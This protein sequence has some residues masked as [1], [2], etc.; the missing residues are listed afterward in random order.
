MSKPGVL[1]KEDAQLGT[2][3][4]QFCGVAGSKNLPAQ[5]LN[6]IGDV[7]DFHLRKLKKPGQCEY[8]ENFVIFYE[9]ALGNFPAP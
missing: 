5:S 9:Y 3:L 7:V 8:P 2:V 1:A 6:F 4:F